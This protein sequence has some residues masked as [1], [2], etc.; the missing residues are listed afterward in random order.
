MQLPLQVVFRNMES[1][2]GVEAKIRE[3][4]EQLERF[5]PHIMSCRVV[6]EAHHKHHH[7]GNVY[8][9]RIDVKVPDAEIVASRDPGAHHAHEDV[10]VAVRDAFDAVARR[11][12]DHARRRRGDIKS[13][14][15]PPHGRIAELG[16][17]SGRIETIDGRL[18]Y[19]HRNS[20]ID[21]DYD[22]LAVGTEVRFVEEAGELGPQASTVHVVGKHHVV[23]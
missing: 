5:H 20:V 21:T 10:Y 9:A 18:V 13:H 1:S 6:V 11:L 3:R 8:H 2:A 22:K 14:E 19:F 23:G 4:V 12:E 7:Q 15:V 16:A 17:D